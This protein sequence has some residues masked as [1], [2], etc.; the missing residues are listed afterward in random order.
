M[1]HKLTYYL[2]LPRSWLK[3]N[4]RQEIDSEDI[5]SLGEAEDP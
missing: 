5:L 1:V 2:P 4:I 3:Y